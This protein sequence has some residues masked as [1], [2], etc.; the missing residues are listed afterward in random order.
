MPL[1]QWTAPLYTATADDFRGELGR[2]SRPGAP[3]G[4][5]SRCAAPSLPWPQVQR[6]CRHQPKSH[7]SPCWLPCLP[8]ELKKQQ[9][10]ASEP[11]PPPDKVPPLP[12]AA[13]EAAGDGS[14]MQGWTPARLRQLAAEAYRSQL[15]P[16]LAALGYASG[17]TSGSTASS[18]FSDEESS[19][20]VIDGLAEPSG[21]AAGSSGSTG[22]GPGPASGGAAAWE[23]ELAAEIAAGEGPVLA[24]LGRYLRHLET[25]AAGG[26]GGEGGN[27]DEE[28]VGQQAALAGA[29]AAFDLPQTP[30]GCFPAL[31]GRC[32]G[33][34]M[35]VGLGWVG[36]GVG[37][38][39]MRPGGWLVHRSRQRMLGATRGGPHLRRRR[40]HEVKVEQV[41][42][43]HRL[44]GQHSHRQV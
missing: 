16:Q 26:A 12:A 27:S 8:A 38:R 6:L 3:A 15:S 14:A 32:V 17:S 13:A 44:H 1:H 4:K 36:V 24:T 22:A 40:V 43:A 21:P 2:N 25:T 18:S 29:I 39:R 33:G 30:D 7:Q 35:C 9:P 37:G 11:L 20:A 10:A 34:S 19:R 28:G 23:A 31:F 42:D 41:V 5:C